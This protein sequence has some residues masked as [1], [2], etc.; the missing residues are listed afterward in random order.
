M[1]ATTA[2]ATIRGGSDSNG[3]DDDDGNDGG[4][5]GDNNGSDS[6]GK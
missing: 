2:T 3:R 1:M 6:D 5:N 4:D